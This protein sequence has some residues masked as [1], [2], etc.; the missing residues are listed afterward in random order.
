MDCEICK[1][2]FTVYRDPMVINCGHSFCKACI[3][4]MKMCPFDKI[5]ITKITKNY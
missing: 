3:N 1:L 5:I 4:S 2:S